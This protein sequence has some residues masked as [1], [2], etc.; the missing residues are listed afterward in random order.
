MTTSMPHSLPVLLFEFPSNLVLIFFN[1][2]QIKSNQIKS[3]PLQL[4]ACNPFLL[5]LLP[6]MPPTRQSLL[7]LILALCFQAARAIRVV[8]MLFPLRRPLSLAPLD[9][10]LHPN[11]NPNLDPSLFPL[12]AVVL[13]VPPQCRRDLR[14]GVYSLRRVRRA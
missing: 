9:P 10:N 6:Y 1:L 5:H 12:V 3:N 7:C 2:N 13:P 8:N 14:R 11:V 4:S